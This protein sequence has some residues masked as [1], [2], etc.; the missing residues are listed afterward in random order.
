MSDAF[1]MHRFFYIYM[2]ASLGFSDGF[3]PSV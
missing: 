1:Y 3:I 2:F